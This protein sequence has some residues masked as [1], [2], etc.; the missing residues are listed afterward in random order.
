MPLN[1]SKA[2]INTLLEQNELAVLLFDKAGQIIFANERAA[3]L[4]WK[5]TAASPQANLD[6]EYWGKPFTFEGEAIPVNQWPPA[7]AL[8]GVKSEGSEARMVRPDGTHYDI[9]MSASPLKTEGGELLGAIVS[10]TDITE[11]RLAEQRITALNTRLEALATER[12][13]GIHL[14]DLIGLSAKHVATIK[15]MFQIA[16]NEMCNVMAWPVGY[17]YIVETPGH[18]HGLTAWYSSEPQHYEVLRRATSAMDFS[19]TESVIGQVLKLRKPICIS[20]L[21]NELFLRRD[22]ALQVGLKSCLA[23]PVLVDGEPAAILEFFH[24]EPIEP[25]DSLLEIIGVIGAHLGQVIEQKRGEQKLHA[26]FDSAPDAQIVTDTTGK[27]VMANRQ[28]VTVFGYSQQELLGQPVEVLVPPKLRTDHIQHRAGYITAPHPR[29]MGIGMELKGIRKDGTELPLEVSLSPIDID[30]EILIASAIRDVT[31]RK[32]LEQRLRDKERLADMGTAAAIFTHEIANP[33]ASI[34]LAALELKEAVSAEDEYLSN[35][36]CAEIDRLSGLLDQFRS[37]NRVT[38]LRVNSVDLSNVITRVIELQSTAW[39]AQG[40][41][42]KLTMPD[43]L[44]VQGDEEKLQ[45]VILNLCKNAVESMSNGGKLAVTG[46]RRRGQV[47]LEVKDTGSGIPED[48]EVFKL[49]T[50]TKPK[51]GGLG[52]YIVKEIIEAHRGTVS[53]VSE[54][55]NG[56]TFRVALPIGA[57]QPI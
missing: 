23:V 42:T 14:M 50:T 46:Y 53:Y 9:S 30:E 41:Q 36:L 56:T 12:A 8:L 24:T 57:K 49:F 37:L 32:A 11:R 35:I 48:V 38:N 7:L 51:G 47:I 18:L 45:Q 33:L 25:Q 31:E 20:N 19:L 26:L 2:V 40:I 10:F 6:T 3:A 52:L 5:Q 54:S 4:A 16:L 43:N 13:R 55:G 22:P 39:L 1:H 21:D 44:F 29:P 34:H 27:I 15:E 28:T 17:A